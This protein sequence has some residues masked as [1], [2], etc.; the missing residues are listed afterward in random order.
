MYQVKHFS[1]TNFFLPA[2]KCSIGTAMPYT[3]YCKPRGYKKISKFFIASCKILCFLFQCRIPTS[4]IHT[5]P[6]WP[7]R[8]HLYRKMIFKPTSLVDQMLLLLFKSLR[9]SFWEAAVVR[10]RLLIYLLIKMYTNIN[11]SDDND[12]YT[13]TTNDIL[14]QT[15]CPQNR[16]CY[17]ITAPMKCSGRVSPIDQYIEKF[18]DFPC[19]FITGKKTKIGPTGMGR[20]KEA[21]CIH[22]IVRY[23]QT[24]KLICCKNFNFYVYFYFSVSLFFFI[25]LDPICDIKC[26]DPSYSDEEW[27]VIVKLTQSGAAISLACMIF[28]IASCMPSRSPP[29]PPCSLFFLQLYGFPYSLY[30]G[31]LLAMHFANFLFPNIIYFFCPHAMNY[32]SIFRYGQIWK[33]ESTCSNTFAWICCHIFLFYLFPSWRL[34]PRKECMVFWWGHICNSE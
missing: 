34:S 20:G 9:I 25:Y 13:N 31:F 1:Y 28:L 22:Q 7:G 12:L 23:Y 15:E 19:P 6:L 27:L 3:K 24:K 4:L 33:E 29:P 11:F 32:F 21:E 10:K 2:Q 8:K 16:T 17:N 14:I 30:L 26:P 5:F 18:P